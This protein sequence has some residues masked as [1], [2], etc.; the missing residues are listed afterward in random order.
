MLK[1]NESPPGQ[2]LLAIRQFNCRD[3]YECHETIEGLW[4][5]ETG[6]MKD[7]L[8]GTLQIS[9][10]MLHWQNGNHGGAV[11]LLAGG[12]NYLKRVP[13]VCLWVDVPALIASA[14][15]VRTALLE[16]GQE[17]MEMLDPGLIPEIKTVSLP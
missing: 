1:C 8:Q 16:L 11:S 13:D 15:R 10:A 5:G 9:V 7:F 3:W 2:L 6:E 14:E 17:R 12:V 4:L